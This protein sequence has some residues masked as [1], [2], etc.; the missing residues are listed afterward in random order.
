MSPSCA[1]RRRPR[2]ATELLAGALAAGAAAILLAGCAGAPARVP[3]APVAS[4]PEPRVASID[5]VDVARP[6]SVP[7]RV[8]YPA[9]GRNLPVV[10]FSHG[11]FSSKDDYVPVTD[12]WAGRG[13]VVIA[14]THV[15]SVALGAARGKPVPGTW[16]GRVADVRFV[17]DHLDAVAAAVPELRGRIDGQRIAVTGHSLGALLAQAFGGMTGSDRETGERYALRDPRIRAIVALSGVGPLAQMTV[18]E[19]FR[20]LSKPLFASVGTDD[21]AMPSASSQS[22][23]ELRRGPFDLA[24]SGRK[25]LLVLRGSDHY[26]GGMVGRDDLPKSPDGAAYVRTFTELSGLF[27]DAWL[28]GDRSARSRLDALR[29]SPEQARVAELTRG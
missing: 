27:L 21:L 12:G 3:V 16:A 10:V 19:D 11:A 26:L 1:A 23:Y 25:Y 9:T 4:K 17:I 18:A 7:L 29:L 22:G 24:P 15:D 14:I 20:G 8:A 6:R 13:Y 5:L 2:G 28:K